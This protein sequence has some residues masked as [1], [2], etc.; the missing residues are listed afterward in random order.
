MNTVIGSELEINTEQD[1]IECFSPLFKL[2]F[3]LFSYKHDFR[4]G[5]YPKNSQELKV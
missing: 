3:L 2:L 4:N 1:K 5:N